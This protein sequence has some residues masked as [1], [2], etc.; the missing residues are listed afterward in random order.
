MDGGEARSIALDVGEAPCASRRELDRLEATAT[1]SYILKA[2][3]QA[4]ADRR[5]GQAPTVHTVAMRP[6]PAARRIEPLT[7]VA[8]ALLVN[9]LVAA[10][11][12]WP[13]Q[14][15]RPHQEGRVDA[16]TEGRSPAALA[17]KPDDA[18]GTPSLPRQ[19]PVPANAR[20][21]AGEP[22]TSIQG[23]PP[24]VRPQKA[25]DHVPGAT[26]I[27]NH[28]L[29]GGRALAPPVR[30]GSAERAAPERKRASGEIIVGQEKGEARGAAALLPPGPPFASPQGGEAKGHGDLGRREGSSGATPALGLP[31][32][33]GQLGAS[34]QRQLQPYEIN[35]I[36]Y[37]EHDA[38][39]FAIVNMR[40][41]YEGD[42]LAGTEMI[43][44]RILRDGAVVDYGDGL[45]RL[46]V[47]PR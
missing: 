29:Q 37:S 40:K 8:A 9:A 6:R 28:R 38:R 24:P 35:V 22:R 12:L 36:S 31:P 43:I 41:Y 16:V 14:P 20:P 39:R 33:V 15:S 3:D 47:G 42:K 44:Q 17:A 10:V 30:K 27:P 26:T 7:L 32:L 2:L 23:A 19:R 18:I 13:H 21:P 46:P 5:R 11:V 34:V 1:M 45:A 25:H 4:E